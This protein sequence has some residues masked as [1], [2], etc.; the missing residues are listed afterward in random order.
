[1]KETADGFASGFLTALGLIAVVLV[2]QQ[3][4]DW[5]RKQGIA[6]SGEA[7][8]AWANAPRFSVFDIVTAVSVLF[9]LWVV[10]WVAAFGPRVR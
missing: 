5:L 9:I 1:V 2:G 8:V 4:V 10:V 7:V 6:A 3:V